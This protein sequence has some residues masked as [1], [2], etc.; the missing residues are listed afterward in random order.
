MKTVR[1]LGESTIIKLIALHAGHTAVYSRHLVTGGFGPMNFGHHAMLA[2]DS[3]EGRN[4]A[5]R[6]ERGQVFPEDFEKPAEGGYSSLKPGAMFKDLSRV[7]SLDG[8]FADLSR[9]PA[10]EGFEALV[11]VSSIKPGDGEILLEATNGKSVRSEIDM[12]L[13][14]GKETF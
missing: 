1:I 13:L 11:M 6:I 5:S 2:F 7:P 8:S 10:R 4:S 9:Y 14:Y 12:P 3:G